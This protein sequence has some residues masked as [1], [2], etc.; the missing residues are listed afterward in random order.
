MKFGVTDV[1][2]CK[3][4]WLDKVIKIQIKS[5]FIKLLKI[6]KKFDKMKVVHYF[7][8]VHKEEVGRGWRLRGWKSW[9]SN[10]DNR[11]VGEQILEDI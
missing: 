6:V 8:K 10:P 2:Y 3:M 11:C 9:P 7:H 1:T 4:N 5:N